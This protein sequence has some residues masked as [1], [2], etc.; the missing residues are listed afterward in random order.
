MAGAAWRAL[1]FASVCYVVHDRVA[2][3]AEVHGPSMQPTLQTEDWLFVDRF[4]HRWPRERPHAVGDVV[5]F[6]SPIA[7]NRLVVKRIAALP[8]DWVDPRNGN[9]PFQ[10]PRGHVWMLGDNPGMS[11]DS[12]AYGPVPMGLIRGRA[13]CLLKPGDRRGP[14]P[15]PPPALSEAPPPLDPPPPAAAAAAAGPAA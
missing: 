1:Q 7:A 5:F 4:S 14:I 10:V 15:G 6:A 9:S 3:V 12:R 13:L 2:I 11:T 8:G